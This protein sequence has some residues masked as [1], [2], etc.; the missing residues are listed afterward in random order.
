MNGE[1]IFEECDNVLIND[2][3]NA[4]PIIPNGRCC[5]RC[6]TRK[7]I[8]HRL[9]LLMF[10]ESGMELEEGQSLG[11]KVDIPNNEQDEQDEE[12]GRVMGSTYFFRGNKNLV[13]AHSNWKEGDEAPWVQSQDTS[14]EYD[15]YTT[16]SGKVKDKS[17]GR[18]RQRN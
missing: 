6:N 2:G 7:V 1:C 5:E 16:Y 18:K 14:T 15:N 4:G 8:P 10:K 9:A 17:S 12:R 13:E 3:H 11:I